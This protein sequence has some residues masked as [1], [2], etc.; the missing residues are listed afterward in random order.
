MKTQDIEY[1]DGDL[2]CHGFAADSD[3]PGKRPAILVVHEAWGL[4][5]HAIARTQKLAE[6]GY[7]AFAAD[8]YGGRKQVT[9]IEEARGILGE[10]RQN[11]P[12]LRARA[13]ARDHG[14]G[15]GGGSEGERAGVSRRR[16]P[17]DS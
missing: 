4:G 2:V 15:A 9:T 13:R 1:R 14:A 5:E 3:K 7:V 10:L 8:M 12:K 16:R 17:V 11:P 6:L